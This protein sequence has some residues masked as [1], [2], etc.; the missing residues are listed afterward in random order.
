ME[1]GVRAWPPAR[2]PADPRGFP[3][4]TSP[5]AV[6]LDQ[7]S[8][9]VPHGSR[10][11]LRVARRRCY[12]P[13]DENANTADGE[14]SMV[15][16][17]LDDG[18]AVITI[19]RPHARNAISLETMD[20]L[21]KAL[22]GAAGR[23]GAGASPA[24]ATGPSS[25]V[26]TSRNS[27]RCAPKRD[28]SAMAFRMRSICD[29]IAGFPGPGDRSA[30]RPRPGRRRRVRGGRR[31]PGGRRRH[32]DRVQPG[33]RWRS[34]RRGAAPS[35]SSRWSA[36]A[37]R[38]CWPA[39]ARILGAAEAERIGLVD[40]VLPRASFDE[41]LARSRPLAGHRPAGEIKRV[42]KGVADHRGRRGL[43][44]AVGVR[45]TLGRRR[46]SDEAR[47]VRSRSVSAPRSRIGSLPSQLDGGLADEL[48]HA[49]GDFV[50][51]HDLD[52]LVAGL[53]GGST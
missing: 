23:R 7:L 27:A 4:S 33:V 50:V 38:C 20:Q 37:R 14:R 31:H 52:D 19:D 47:Q 16:L 48:A 8:R 2:R 10:P 22:D 29:R 46:Q 3:A 41:R 26:A 5:S 1:A 34:C 36:T 49:G 17:E 12:S 32:Q 13:P 35:G 53:F 11:H 24:P 6:A 9:D 44:A 51:F 39:P 25:P 18:L 28:A 21:E 30:E 45:R 43:R 42:M 15:D 40:Q